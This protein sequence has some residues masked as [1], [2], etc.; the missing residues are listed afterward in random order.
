MKKVILSIIAL[1]LLASCSQNLDQ[2][3]TDV[4]PTEDMEKVD[5]A[6]QAGPLLSN[7][8]LRMHTMGSGTDYT[9]YKVQ[10]LAMDLM[11]N[12]MIMPVSGHSG[13]HY[14]DYQMMYY[15]TQTDSRPS[16][17][18]SNYYKNIFQANQ[19]MEFLPADLSTASNPALAKLIKAQA[20]TFRAFNYYHLITLFQ[21]AYLHGGKDKAG[22]PYYTRSDEEAKGRGNA[23]DVYDSIMVDITEAIAL[24]KESGMAPSSKEDIS[25]YV[26]YM[27]QARLALTMGQYSLAASA[28]GE[29]IKGFSLMSKDQAMANGFQKL[30]S[31]EAIWGYQWVLSTSLQNNSFSSHISAN[32]NG[33]YGGS[34]GGFKII[35]ERLYNKIAA[36]DW[37]KELYYAAPT[38][39]SYTSYASKEAPAYTNKKFNSVSYECDEVYMRAAE[40]YFIKAE[41]EAKS[42]GDA[43]QTL[44]N[45][46]S[47]RDAS[48]TK[49]TKSGQALV[50]EIMLH[51]RIEMW[52]EGLEFYDNKRL[53][54]GVDRSS[55]Q[56]HTVMKTVPAGKDF[57]FQIPLSG[58][59]ELNP[60]I[61]KDK[62]QNPY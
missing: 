26:A 50:D 8:V 34:G 42:T 38:V 5:P 55:S 10:Q 39:I 20:K 40:A 29:V 3:P 48:Y 54:I 7:A 6:Q 44:Y 36:S 32:C 47:T 53:N 60:N 31:P 18:W 51:K 52:G 59:I 11:G 13:W 22:I 16:S 45:I 17:Q 27:V 4:F 28:A 25:I 58:E 37:R 61:D 2:S 56:N 43:A 19:A 35:D 9:S 46:V 41:A 62:D 33:G 12:D 14:N 30:S 49:S 24:F 23:K 57:T 21:D 1:G 15:R